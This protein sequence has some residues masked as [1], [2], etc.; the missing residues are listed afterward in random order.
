[1]QTWQRTVI[2]IGSCDI[3]VCSGL[4]HDLFVGDAEFR[5]PRTRAGTS[6]EGSPNMPATQSPY[7]PHANNVSTNESAKVAMRRTRRVRETSGS[8][9][10]G[11]GHDSDDTPKPVGK[12]RNTMNK[13]VGVLG[14]VVLKKVLRNELLVYICVTLSIVHCQA[15]QML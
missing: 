15:N 14:A 8:S 4:V 9:G 6:G 13:M 1:M 2:K 7:T 5:G 3:S 12:S 10:R 11:D